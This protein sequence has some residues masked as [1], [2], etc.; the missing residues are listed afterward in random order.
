MG[1]ASTFIDPA[2]LQGDAGVD[3]T[4]VGGF[5]CTANASNILTWRKGS[6][7]VAHYVCKTGALDA[8][9]YYYS[10]DLHRV[11]HIFHPFHPRVAVAFTN[12]T[13]ALGGLVYT[14]IGVLDGG[15]CG[16]VC[17]EDNSI[18]GRVVFNGSVCEKLSAASCQAFEPDFC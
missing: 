12:S 2:M 11:K 1:A 15:S 5:R 18:A 17:A 8:S 13:P 6:A 16:V 3:A 7:S 4:W 10:S 14:D 9:S